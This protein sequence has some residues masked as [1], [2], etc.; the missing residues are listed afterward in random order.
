MKRR[1]FLLFIIALSVSLFIAGCQNDERGPE[2]VFQDY[3][4]LWNQREF[5]AMYPFLT[6]SAKEMVSEEEFVSRYEKIYADLEV[7]DLQVAFEPPEEVDVEGEEVSF[8][9]TVS[10][11]TIAGPV[12]FEQVARLIKVEDEEETNW[13]VDWHPGYI[14]AGMESGDRVGL[15]I[16]KAP[17][18]EI[19]DRHGNGLAINGEVYEVGLVPEKMEGQE[20]RIIHDLAEKLGLSV[21][22]IEKK[23]SASWVQPHFFVPI[24]RV[25]KTNQALIDEV[26]EIPGVQVNTTE[27]RVYPLAEAGAHLI[28]YVD[29]VTAEDLEKNEGYRAGDVIGKRGLEQ[30]LEERLRGESGATIYIEKPDGST[31]PIAEKQAVPGEDIRLTIDSEMQRLLFAKF[32]GKGGTAVAIHPQTGETLAL[33][34]S[35]SFDPNEYMFM[36]AAARQKLADEPNEPLLNRFVYPHTP[37]SVIKPLVAAI[38]LETGTIDPEHT[39]DIQGDQ[40]QKDDS[41][42]GYKITR[43][44]DPGRPVN[45]QDALVLSDNIFFAQTALELGADRFISGLKRFGFAE[46]IPFTY[47]LESSQISNS[48][49]LDDE[50]LL[51]DSGYGQGEVQMNIVHLAS[52]FTIFVNDGSMIQPILL[53][54]EA[55]G[56]FWKE[57]VVSPEN[58]GII[59]ESLRK[60]VANPNGTGR[61]ADIPGLSLA[62]KTGTA[63]LAKAAQGEQGEENGWFVAYDTD[64]KDVLVVMMM[65]GVEQ[66]GSS[67]VVRAVRDF[68]AEIR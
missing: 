21:E 51:A 46:K 55:K 61:L 56:Q 7:T 45:L 34:S 8:P 1:Q 25:P 22:D 15:R 11:N 30:L 62:G 48:G 57:K 66:E 4:E 23:L 27:A 63:E 26:L 38:G 12:H 24:K 59:A 14:F 18:G 6:D 65:E 33:V 19:F 29:E 10:M 58:T 42:G 43:V 32:A 41:W 5:T 20:D 40:W 44:T 3:V 35:P 2:D 9:F 53:Q 67:A 13:F 39:R 60:V 17:R 36:T 47:P 54:E 31:I 16:E 49:E 68:F 52:A 28:G 64:D 37:G 50:I